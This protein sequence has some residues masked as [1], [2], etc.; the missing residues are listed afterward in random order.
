MVVAIAE[1]VDRRDDGTC[2]KL[3]EVARRLDVHPDTVTKLTRSGQLPVV[4][5]ASAK[6]VR[7]VDL[8]AYLD[9]S[10]P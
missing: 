8:I 3:S 1:A 5:V 7:L 6:R 2:L 4:H 10:H 9:R